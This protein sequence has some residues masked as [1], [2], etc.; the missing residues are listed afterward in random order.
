MEI[1]ESDM[2]FSFRDGVTAVKYD[3]EPFY[4]KQYN[5]AEGTKGVDIVADCDTVMYFIEIKNCEGTAEN[6]DTWRRHY[7]GTK[8]MDTLATE[9]ALK[10]AHTC[11]CL[12]GVS[13]YAERKEGAVRLLNYAHALHAPNIASLD[14]KLLVL[15]YLEGDF[16][17]QSRTN[18]MIYGDL[19]KRIARRLKWLNCKVDVVSTKKRS[20]RD[21]EVTQLRQVIDN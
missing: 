6:Q 18:E 4:K 19:K 2:L 9:V 14:K 10:V 8:N 15:L 20:P 5:V 7:S 1:R 17:C 3:D 21:F 16:S 11:A 13:T 12:T